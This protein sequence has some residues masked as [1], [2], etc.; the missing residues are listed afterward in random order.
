M[1]QQTHLAAFRIH[2]RSVTLGKVGALKGFTL[3][4]NTALYSESKL[5][6]VRRVLG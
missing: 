6:A 3:A 5:Y 1:L 4:G 2:N